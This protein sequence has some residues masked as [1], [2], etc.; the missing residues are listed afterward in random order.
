MGKQIPTRDPAKKLDRMSH[1]ELLI[2]ANRVAGRRGKIK[3]SAD[4][5][6]F[7]VWDNRELRFYIQDHWNLLYPEE[8]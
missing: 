1:P 8:E 5:A 7:L 3:G 4:R 2:I 6:K